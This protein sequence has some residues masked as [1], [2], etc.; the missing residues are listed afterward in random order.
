M[1]KSFVLSLIFLVLTVSFVYANEKKP[2]AISPGEEVGSA[3][4]WTPSG[5]R[6]LT[7]GVDY[8]WYV[9]AVDANGNGVWSS[10]KQFKVN[11]TVSFD[12][13]LDRIKVQLKEY[14]IGE[15]AGY[16]NQTGYRNVF[17]GQDAGFFE[18]G[19][20]NLYIDTTSTSSPLIY[21]DFNTNIV[22]INGKL[23]VGSSG[24]F[25]PTV[26]VDVDG[27]VK[28]KYFMQRSE[29][30]Q[31][32]WYETDGADSADFFKMNYHANSLEF[33]WYDASTA[34]TY[35][36]ILMKGNGYVGI[37]N[38]NPTHMLDVGASGA[39]CNGGAWVNGSSIEYKENVRNVGLDEAI[40][41]L[42]DLKPVK[43]NYKEDKEEQYL[44]F[45][46]EDV[47]EL[48]AMNERKGLHTMDVVTV[49]TKVASISRVAILSTLWR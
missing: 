35:T 19:S 38:S 4:S 17:I 45:I 31:M 48:V 1:K 5:S 29:A 9:Q 22:S 7:N 28:T 13:M 41:T 40:D 10:G 26:E 21:G 47:P 42:K 33:I 11:L 49:L 16:S 3:L 36:P 39:Y 43:Y 24:N 14:G 12:K 8:I 44:G 15:D 32:R 34:T 30:P 6:G 23:G 25:T 20:H 46:A 37:N 18:T 2:I 27:Y